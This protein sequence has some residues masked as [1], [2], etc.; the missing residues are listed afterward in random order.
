M[1]LTFRCNISAKVAACKQRQYST[2]QYRENKH[3]V[4]EIFLTDSQ[5]K[6]WQ[7]TKQVEKKEDNFTQEVEG[8][9]DLDELRKE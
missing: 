6:E 8:G 1:L 3:L 5:L 2:V 7:N 9:P 4:K